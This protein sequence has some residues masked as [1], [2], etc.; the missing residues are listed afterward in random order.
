MSSDGPRSLEGMED[1]LTLGQTTRA[2]TRRWAPEDSLL[3]LLLSDPQVAAWLELED[4][5]HA[6]SLSYA[7][8]PTG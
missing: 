6:S 8:S 3:E 4:D 7:E 1:A 2:S 5:P